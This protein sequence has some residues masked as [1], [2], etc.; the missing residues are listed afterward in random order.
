MRNVRMKFSGSEIQELETLIAKLERYPKDKQKNI[1][2]K[3]RKKGLDEYLKR[4]NT[5]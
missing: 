3:L 5:K 2:N 4:K 1:R